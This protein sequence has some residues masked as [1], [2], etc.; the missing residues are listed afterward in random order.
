MLVLPLVNCYYWHLD[1]VLVV[2]FLILVFGFACCLIWLIL[3]FDSGCL[4]VVLGCYCFDVFVSLLFVCDL[5]WL[6]VLLNLIH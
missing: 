4:V 2:I 3:L 6:C 1:C 5:M